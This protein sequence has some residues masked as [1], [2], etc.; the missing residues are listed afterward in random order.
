VDDHRRV[1]YLV[2][3]LDALITKNTAKRREIKIIAFWRSEHQAD[4]AHKKRQS[5]RHESLELAR[6]GVYV[7]GADQH[8]DQVCADDAQGRSNGRADQR[9]KRC[10]SCTHLERNDYRCDDRTENGRDQSFRF[11]SSPGEIVEQADPG[12]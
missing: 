7:L 10:F 9:F 2:I 1:E 4:V 11:G 5:Y 6:N 12:E 3:A 8:S